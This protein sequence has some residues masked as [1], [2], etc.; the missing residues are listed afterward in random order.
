MEERKVLMTIQV[1]ESIRN[2]IKSDAA[3]KGMFIKDYLIALVEK[4]DKKSQEKA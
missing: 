2:K 3:M 4:N 1:P